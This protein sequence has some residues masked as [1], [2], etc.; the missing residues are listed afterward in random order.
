[1]A[2]VFLFFFGGWP[3]AGLLPEERRGEE[4][5]EAAA[6]HDLMVADLRGAGM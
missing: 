6:L 4:A 3:R 2:G 1:V 5:E